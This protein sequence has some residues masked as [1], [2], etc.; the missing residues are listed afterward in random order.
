MPEPSPYRPWSRWNR[1][2]QQVLARDHE[3]CQIRTH[4]DGAHA[5]EVDHITP[6]RD[7][8]AWFDLDNLRAACKACNIARSSLQKHHRGWQRAATEIVLVMR[9]ADWRPEPGDMII[10]VERLTACLAAGEPTVHHRKMA[11]E[12]HT[13]LIARLNRGELDAPKV[14]VIVDS[15]DAGDMIPHH[16]MITAHQ[17]ADAGSLHA[18]ETGRW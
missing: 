4:C 16:S 8:G 7:G 2:R 9:G 3:V 14:W 15:P 12:L 10:D 13:K 1:I 18:V 5:N 11:S 6:W 17:T